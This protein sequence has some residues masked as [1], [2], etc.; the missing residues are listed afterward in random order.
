MLN[1]KL[2]KNI[3]FFFNVCF[4]NEYATCFPPKINCIFHSANN[5]SFIYNFAGILIFHIHIYVHVLITTDPVSTKS[6][7]MAGDIEDLSELEDSQ[8]AD[9]N[10]QKCPDN[11]TTRQKT[12]TRETI[13]ISVTVVVIVLIFVI[14]V[15][16]LVSR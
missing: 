9:D 4:V 14:I 7:G 3:F 5:N 12:L 6:P 16:I 15:A 13:V 1:Y 2:Q 10:S 11:S 8:S